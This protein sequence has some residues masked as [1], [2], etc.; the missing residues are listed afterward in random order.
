MRKKSMDE[1]RDILDNTALEIAQLD[2]NPNTW[3]SW[4]MY[5]LDRLEAQAT[6]NS[7]QMDAFKDM[8]ATLQDKLR[9]R[10]KTGGW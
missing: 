3:Q 2:S 10:L 9:N 7:A 8:L 5:L 1:L 4:M 6:Q